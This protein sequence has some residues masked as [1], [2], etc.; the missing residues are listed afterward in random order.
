MPPLTES[1][2]WNSLLTTTLANYR[3]QMIDKEIV[4]VKSTLINGERLPD[5]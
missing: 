4:D 1:R 5:E 2:D 3:Q